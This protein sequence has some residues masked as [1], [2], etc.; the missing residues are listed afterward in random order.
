M[1]H[2]NLRSNRAVQ[3]G[4]SLSTSDKASGND[5]WH[6]TYNR[7]ATNED[8]LTYDDLVQIVL[9]DKHFTLEWLYDKNILARNRTCPECGEHMKLIETSDR[10]DG[11]KWSCTRKINNRRHFKELSIRHKSWFSGSNMSIEEI[12]KY[13]YWWSL[14][15]EQDVII[16]QL[17][18]SSKTTVDWSMFCRETC[19]EIMTQQN[20]Q[21]GGKDK[22]V[23][24]DESKIGK[25]KYHRGHLV[26]G[27]WVFG[28]IE[29][30]SRK[31]FLVAVE[32]RS[33]ETLLPIIKKHISVGST[34]V[35]DC[36]KAYHNLSDHGYLHQT[37]NHS[38]EFK[39]DEGFHTN[40]IEGHWRQVKAFLPSFSRKKAHQPSYLAEFLYR[41]QHPKE[42]LFSHFIQD[43]AKIYNPYN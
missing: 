6:R 35:S 32:D 2:Y 8:V 21:L 19:L 1:A 43:I 31:S 15:V 11:L 13:T 3:A 24:I 10:H 30:D 27:Q 37:V 28:G 20:I 4:S 26:E 40:T 7:N 12:L 5:V 36:W 17:K 33:E 9:C 16:S 41:Y 25:R 22:I 42:N 38:V 39:N 34:I 18:L 29:R 14:G 23:E